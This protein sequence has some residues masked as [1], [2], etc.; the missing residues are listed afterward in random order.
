MLV[1]WAQQ[2]DVAMLPLDRNLSPLL[3][4]CRERG[5]M[6]WPKTMV[7]PVRLRSL[8]FLTGVGACFIVVGTSKMLSTRTTRDVWSGTIRESSVER[9]W[10][11]DWVFPC[12]VYINSNRHN[13]RIWVSL[14][15]GSHHVDNLTNSLSLLVADVV[16]LVMLN[17]LQLLYD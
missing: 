4:G 15:C 10:R 16:L 11:V 13:S 14:I 3:Q 7:E 1:L 17:C 2:A 9:M 6:R 12:R 8:R 5:G